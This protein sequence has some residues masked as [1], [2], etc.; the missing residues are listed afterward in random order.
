MTYLGLRCSRYIN[1]VAM[2]HG[3]IS[4]GM[5]PNY[6]IHAITNGV[7]A[8]TWTSKPFQELFDLHI[9]E[10]RRDKLYLRYVVGIPVEEILRAHAVAKREMIQEISSATGIRL[11]E[12]VATLG[13]AR[14][15]AAYK[16]AD[17][18]FTD[19]Q[20]LRTIQAHSGALQSFTVARLIR[21]MGRGK[22]R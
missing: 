4:H 9:P 14:R 21:A 3:E 16:R 20:R 17:L 2:H 18:L 10:W 1:G 22:A 13:F 7:H 11:S 15:A 19:L 12:Q 8:I 6:P 5:Y